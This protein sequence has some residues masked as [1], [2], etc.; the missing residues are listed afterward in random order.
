MDGGRNGEMD[1]GRDGRGERLT[2][3]EMDGGRD[4]GRD[5]RVGERWLER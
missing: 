4:G 5:G 2:G 1:G 3:G